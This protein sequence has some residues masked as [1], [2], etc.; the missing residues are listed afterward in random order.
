M[1]TT[2]RIIPAIAYIV[3]TNL[4]GLAAVWLGHRLATV[5]PAG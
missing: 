3:S 2:A 1:L 4:L 5:L